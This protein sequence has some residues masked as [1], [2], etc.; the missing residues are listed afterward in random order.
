MMGLVI[1]LH[2]VACIL[3]IVVV[4]IQAGRQGGLAAGFSQVESLFGAKTSESLVKATT[5]FLTIFL[6]TSLTLTILSSR[7]E[8][9]LLSNGSV[10][11]VRAAQPVKPI[12][13]PAAQPVTTPVVDAAK[14]VAPKS[15]QTQ[16][17]VPEQKPVK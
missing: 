7:R 4:L 5:I 8:R 17:V 6:V 9:S 16:V 10:K 13:T 12:T 14:S 15:T 11:K 3:I 2:V 1:F